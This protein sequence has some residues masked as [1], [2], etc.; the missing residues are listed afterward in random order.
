MNLIIC[1]YRS[2]SCFSY[3]GFLLFVGTNLLH[4]RVKLVQSVIHNKNIPNTF[5][6][7]YTS[8]CTGLPYT[9]IIMVVPQTNLIN[10]QGNFVLAHYRCIGI[11]HFLFTHQVLRTLEIP[12]GWP[13]WMAK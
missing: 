6:H 8:T 7:I 5:F 3:M 12:C 11:L 9:T 4:S 1:Q 2:Q 13:R 10:K